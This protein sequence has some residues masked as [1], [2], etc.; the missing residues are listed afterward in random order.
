MKPRAIPAL[1]CLLLIAVTAHADLLGLQVMNR[2]ERGEY[3]ARAAGSGNWA[4]SGSVQVEHSRAG[5]V[6]NSVRATGRVSATARGDRNRVN[7]ASVVLRDS[8]A[9]EVANRVEAN[10]IDNQVEG[11]DNISNIG[12]VVLDGS[13]VRRVSFGVRAGSVH[14]SI[15]GSGNR[16]NIGS[17]HMGGA[18]GGTVSE[19]VELDNVSVSVN[20]DHRTWPLIQWSSSERHEGQRF[21]GDPAPGG[22]AGPA[23]C[24][25]LPHGTGR[26]PGRRYSHR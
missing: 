1:A 25:R 14:G 2:A 20:G 12:A 24:R 18:V 6:V 23:L 3:A 17:V 5:R 15:R 10:S 19:Q 16:L 26:R 7:T 13:R 9:G 11:N 22:P 4:N 8:E 21:H